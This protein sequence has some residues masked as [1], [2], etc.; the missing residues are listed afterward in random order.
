MVCFFCFSKNCWLLLQFQ[1]QLPAV[2][3]GTSTHNLG[4]TTLACFS[5]ERKQ[6]FCSPK[7]Q[8]YFCKEFNLLA[9]FF[10]LTKQLL[11][12]GFVFV[13]HK[14]TTRRNPS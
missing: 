7:T 1:I 11:F 3:Q 4:T 9:E 12:S 14:F 8:A 2:V 5:L 10:P 13:T 6:S